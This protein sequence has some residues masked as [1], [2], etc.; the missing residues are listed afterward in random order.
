[1]IAKNYPYEKIVREGLK[2]LDGPLFL[3]EAA[4]NVAGNLVTVRR[5]QFGYTIEINRRV[6]MSVDNASDVQLM[7]RSFNFVI[8]T[9]AS[10][11]YVDGKRVDEDTAFDALVS[12]PGHP[13]FSRDGYEGWYFRMMLLIRRLQLMVAGD[14]IDRTLPT[15]R[16]VT[17]RFSRKNLYLKSGAMVIKCA[18][19]EAAPKAQLSDVA[20]IVCASPKQPYR[21]NAL[22]FHIEKYNATCWLQDGKRG[23]RQLCVG[24]GRARRT[25][26]E[27][28]LTGEN[29]LVYAVV[30]ST[31]EG[32]VN[33]E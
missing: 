24:A 7:L 16:R 6:K 29:P 9:R 12:L 31:A 15:G 4:L 27:C 22:D 3:N 13:R 32:G 18:R 19:N 25:V 1:M 28:F 5:E 33:I 21:W 30:G 23:K 17:I 2:K 10:G 8:D 20:R 26:C 14:R 11:V